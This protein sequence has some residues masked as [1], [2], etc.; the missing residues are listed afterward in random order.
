M[1]SKAPWVGGPVPSTKGRG[2][3]RKERRRSLFCSSVRCRRAAVTGTQSTGIR[4][5]LCALQRRV[6]VYVCVCPLSG[7]AGRGPAVGEEGTRRPEGFLE[8]WIE[9]LGVGAVH[10]W[11]C[12][13]GAS[14]LYA[15]VGGTGRGGSVRSIGSNSSPFGR[16]RV[17]GS[18]KC[19]R[20]T[21]AV[22]SSA[23]VAAVVPVSTLR[24]THSKASTAPIRPSP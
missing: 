3:S 15:R 20:H 6:C 14:L 11:G 4:A 22:A 1:Q 21:A 17:S 7:A 10:C 19:Q 23:I 13:L 2:E 5:P 9:R 12:P 24:R 16:G 8:R 18:R